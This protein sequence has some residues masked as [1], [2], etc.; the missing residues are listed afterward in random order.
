M[1]GQDMISYDIDQITLG[2]YIPL[3]TIPYHLQKTAGATCW[4]TTTA[5]TGWPRGG[6]G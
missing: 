6:A 5:A 1:I 4:P 2:N 3:F